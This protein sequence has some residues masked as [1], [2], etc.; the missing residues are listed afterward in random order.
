[1]ERRRRAR[2][3]KN[4]RI[5][6]RT[7]VTGRTLRF[8]RS[9][10][11]KAKTLQSTQLVKN[12]NAPCGFT[13]GRAGG[14]DKWRPGFRNDSRLLC[15]LLISHFFLFFLFFLFF[16]FFSL[17]FFFFLFFSFFFFF[18]LFFLFFSFLFVAPQRAARARL[19]ACQ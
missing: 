10:S 13:R 14:K 9:A 17:F 15:A 2:M 11:Q 6:R 16:S 19:Q 5:G 1:M 8:P 4:R 12:I 3:G 7:E 18:F